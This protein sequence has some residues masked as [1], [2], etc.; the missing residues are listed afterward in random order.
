MGAPRQ[1]RGGRRLC[2]E[3]ATRIQPRKLLWEHESQIRL[4]R[5][6]SLSYSTPDTYIYLYTR[7]EIV[8]EDIFLPRATQ[9]PCPPPPP[10]W[11]VKIPLR[12]CV[13]KISKVWNAVRE[14]H[15]IRVIYI[16]ASILF[17]SWNFF[18][19]MVHQRLFIS[20]GRYSRDVKNLKSGREMKFE[21]VM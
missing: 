15:A 5:L 20:V 3:F 9:Y 4:Y 16:F 8:S 14:L 13:L 19:V 1:S 21:Y 6:A 7:N 10:S 11:K 12:K 2:E 18:L 17:P